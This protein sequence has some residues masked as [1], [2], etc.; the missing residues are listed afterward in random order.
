MGIKTEIQYFICSIKHCYEHIAINL[1]VY[2]I[3]YLSG[4]LKIREHQ[5]IKWVSPKDLEK[6]DFSDADTLVVERWQKPPLFIY[7]LIL[8]RS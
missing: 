1:M 8:P 2:N 3:K 5:Y 4:E 6:H 7:S